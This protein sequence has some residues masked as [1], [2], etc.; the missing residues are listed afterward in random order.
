[1]DNVFIAKLNENTL[2]T[3]PTDVMVHKH[4]T[5]ACT[6][7]YAH[8]HTHTLAAFRYTSLGRAGFKVAV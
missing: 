6:H 7:T 2:K 4:S 8:A 1:M 5:R 3:T